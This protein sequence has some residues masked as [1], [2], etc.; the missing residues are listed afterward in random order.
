MSKKGGVSCLAFIEVAGGF[1]ELLFFYK[2]L[3]QKANGE[4]AKPAAKAL[5]C[6]L[7]A[8]DAL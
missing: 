2:F 1:Y 3:G 7:F 8:L 6:P 5:F 4:F